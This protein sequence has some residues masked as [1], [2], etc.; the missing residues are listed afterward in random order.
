MEGGS[1]EWAAA[2]AG[3]PTVTLLNFLLTD[4]AVYVLADTVLSDPDDLSP[5]SFATKVHALPHLQAVI[6]GTGHAQSI[7]EWVALVNLSLPARDI[8][9]LDRFAP[10]KLRELFMQ[11][12]NKDTGG[13]D[14]TTT[15]YHLGFDQRGRRFVGFAYRSADNF[16][17][18]PLPQGFGFK[19][20][21]DWPVDST[22]ITRLPEHLIGI[23]KRQK[24]QDEATEAAKRVMVGGQLIFCVMQLIPGLRSDPTV[25]TSLGICHSF[26]DFEQMFARAVAK[27][28]NT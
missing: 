20:A 2:R 14:I 27:L 12:S 17:S 9:Q 1:Y 15:L 21:P 13:R 25:Q 18:E 16:R 4:E 11:Y 28:E 5:V 6:C 8:V 24:A 23:A 22:K 10:A 3:R 26:P 7:A 19:P